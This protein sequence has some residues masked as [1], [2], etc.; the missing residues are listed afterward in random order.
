MAC[1]L[2]REI[3]HLE[4]KEDVSALVQIGKEETEELEYVPAELYVKHYIRPKYAKPNGEGIVIADLPARPIEKGNAG[5]GF[6]AHMIVSKYV[7]HAPFYRLQHQ[8]R[9]RKVE[10]AE[11]TMNGWMKACGIA[12]LPLHELLRVPLQQS[13]YLEDILAKPGVAAVGCFA[14]ARRYFEQAQDSDRERAE[15]MLMKLQ[16]LYGIEREAREANMSF[17]ERHA[18]RQEHALPI[19]QEIKSWLHQHSTQVLPK[20]AMGKAIGYML[21]QWSKLKA[22]TRDGRLE[23]DNNLVENAVR[24]VALGRKNYLFAGSHESAKRA[25]IMYSLLAIAKRHNVEP[26]AYLKH[27]LTRI[28]DHPLHKLAVLLPQN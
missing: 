11:S 22:Y 15:W 4:P 21:G 9:R 27:I 7:D 3:I 17:E 14:H 26:F 24:P 1:H 6:M 13:S 12:L 8:C 16:A 28:S 23:I 19:L 5:P 25:A 10:I 2:R 18:H 20:R